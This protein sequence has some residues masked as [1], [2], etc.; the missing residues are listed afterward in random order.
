MLLL[1]I[2]AQA[3]E[4]ETVYVTFTSKV[5]GETEGVIKSYPKQRET[6]LSEP[7]AFRINSYLYE[8]TLIPAIL[9][10]IVAISALVIVPSGLNLPSGYP[11]A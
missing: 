9:A 2:V 8:L 7:M 10:I 1:G 3:Q 6:H 5:S 4:R 11:D